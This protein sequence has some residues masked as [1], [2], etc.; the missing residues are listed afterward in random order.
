MPRFIFL[1]IAWMK[2]YRG[3]TENDIP[4]GA[5]WYVTENSDGGEV[6]NFLPIR[7]KYYG[8]ARIQMGRGLRL[9]R[10]GASLNDHSIDDVTIIFFGRNPQT[11]GQYIIGWYTRAILYRR[12]QELDNE[13]RGN[14]P[15]Y[16]AETKSAYLVSE[17]DRIFEVPDDGP[18]QTNAWYVEQYGNVYL[19]EVKNYIA[20]PTNYIIR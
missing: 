7:D 11:G 8:Y 20:D 14:Q 13:R 1:R 9:E 19:N 6:Y 15:H 12:M 5:G 18:G 2:Y 16:L 10:L 3:V 17:D 4:T